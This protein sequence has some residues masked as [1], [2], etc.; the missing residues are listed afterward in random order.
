MRQV[1]QQFILTL[2]LPIQAETD[3][4]HQIGECAK[5]FLEILQRSIASRPWTKERASRL[6]SRCVMGERQ[7]AIL[8]IAAKPVAQS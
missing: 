8:T 2:G 3:R 6:Q 4:G 5:A 1:G 7:I